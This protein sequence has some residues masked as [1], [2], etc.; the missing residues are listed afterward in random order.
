MSALRMVVGRQ[1]RVGI[2]APRPT[3][4]DMRIVAEAPTGYT[5]H[6]DRYHGQMR[7]AS[8]LASRRPPPTR[9]RDAGRVAS[10]CRD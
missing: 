5:R 7:S 9:S 1:P 3:A 2:A 6:R 8:S 10:G 4:A